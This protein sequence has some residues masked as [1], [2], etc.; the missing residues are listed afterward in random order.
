MTTDYRS[1][2]S[3]DFT[4]KVH[5]FSRL[6]SPKSFRVW[7]NHM[8]LMNHMENRQ[9]VKFQ[10]E[11]I[12]RLGEPQVFDEPHGISPNFRISARNHFAFGK[13]THVSD[14]PPGKSPNFQMSTQ[15]RKRRNLIWKNHIFL[16]NHMKYRLTSEF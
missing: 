10:P 16:M 5:G 7:K 6:F 2:A 12:S 13:T 4:G 3:S 9:I 8:C 11:I 15:N 14:E 1:I